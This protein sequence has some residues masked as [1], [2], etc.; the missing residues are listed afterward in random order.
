MLLAA[1]FS[2]LCPEHMVTVVARGALRNTGPA[3]WPRRPSVRAPEGMKQDL[4]LGTALHE[5]TLAKA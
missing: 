1:C 3:C 2:R 4:A 5:L